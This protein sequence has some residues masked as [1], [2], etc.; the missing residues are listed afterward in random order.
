M[1]KGR[2]MVSYI[3]RLLFEFRSRKYRISFIAATRV[4]SRIEPKKEYRAVL[5]QWGKSNRNPWLFA[6][7]F[8]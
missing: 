4:L 1:V 8:T 7:S 6:T 5:P 2:G 3:G